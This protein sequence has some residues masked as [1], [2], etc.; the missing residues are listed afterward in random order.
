[1]K[2]IT[3]AHARAGGG[4]MTEVIIVAHAGVCAGAGAGA[5]V[6]VMTHRSMV[7]SGAVLTH[8]RAAH[9]LLVPLRP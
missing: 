9:L 2:A 3:A 8:D 6:K 5:T 7:E 4:M 1:M